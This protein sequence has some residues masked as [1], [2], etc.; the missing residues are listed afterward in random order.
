MTALATGNQGG[1]S[2]NLSAPHE[3]NFDMT[4][5]KNIPLGRNEK[6][7]LKIQV[8]AY[9]VFNHTEISGIASGITFNPTTNVIS[10][11]TAIGYMNGAQPNRVV[12]FSARLQF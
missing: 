1:G 8:Q 4:L 12:A 2:G 11:P 10:N 5:T 9:N 3:T 7:V 6:C